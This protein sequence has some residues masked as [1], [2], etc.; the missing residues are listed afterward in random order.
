MSDGDALL[1]MILANPADQAPWLVWADWLDDHGDE[2]RAKYA[3]QLHMILG[4]V[5]AK[6]VRTLKDCRLSYVNHTSFIDSMVSYH[7]AVVSG[8]FEC[9]PLTLK[10]WQFIWHLT[11]RYRRQHANDTL[12]EL[13]KQRAPAYTWE[14]KN[15]HEA[16]VRPLNNM[17]VRINAVA[18]AL[19]AADMTNLVAE[20]R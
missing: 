18:R 4:D 3:R 16:E 19:L 11:W 2:S 12:T 9:A 10:Q 6:S 5:E 14:T 7:D 1:A 15:S 20:R 17:P 8:L 13:A